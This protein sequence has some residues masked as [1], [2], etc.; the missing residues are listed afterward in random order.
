MVL[1]TSMSRNA[2]SNFGETTSPSTAVTSPNVLGAEIHFPLP[3]FEHLEKH[4]NR[5]EQRHETFK[6]DR[7]E[8]KNVQLLRA[9]PE[10]LTKVELENEVVEKVVNYANLTGDDGILLN[11]KN[12]EVVK[13]LA[14]MKGNIEALIKEAF[15]HQVGHKAVE[16][17]RDA[18]V[19]ALDNMKNKYLSDMKDMEMKLA[20]KE[21]AYQALQL[22]LKEVATRLESDHNDLSDKYTT[23]SIENGNLKEENGNLKEE[24]GNLKEENGKLISENK[25]SKSTGG[26]IEAKCATLAAEIEKLVSKNKSLES[27]VTE[28][29]TKCTKMASEN[30]NLKASIDKLGS[31][32]LAYALEKTN[33]Q[34]KNATLREKNAKLQDESQRAIGLEAE[35]ARVRAKHAD[36]NKK[37]QS[38]RS[39]ETHL[40]A[41]IKTLHEKGAKLKKDVQ[42]EKDRVAELGPK[43]TALEATKDGNESEISELKDALKAME[44]RLRIGCSLVAIFLFLIATILTRS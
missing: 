29:K 38:T 30:R 18:K 27:T 24:N 31:E 12:E 40:E 10:S 37:H 20:E 39:R 16:E 34:E 21:A 41:K 4:L 25:A 11:E 13:T 33:L 36:L 32:K 17:D 26:D 1:S 19:E 44:G 6:R 22:Q 28:A 8:E 2:S 14:S 23:M 7:R 35:L 5:Q 42:T 43:V 3:T 15:K 9:R